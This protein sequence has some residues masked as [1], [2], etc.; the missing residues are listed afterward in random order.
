MT[1]ARVSRPPGFDMT[2]KPAGSVSF[3]PPLAESWLAFVYLAFSLLVLAVILYGYNAPSSS[4]VFAYIVE[5]DQHRILSSTVCGGILL[6]SALAA[7][8]RGQMRGVIIHPDG[9]EMRELLTFGIP[10]VRRYHWSQIDRVMV[11]AA[12][13]DAVPTKHTLVGI[14]LWDG[15]R[16]W[17][18]KVAKL[19]DLAVMIEK[20]ALAR[21]I[22]IDGGTGLIDDLGNPLD[23]DLEDAA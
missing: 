23:E 3:G 13:Q 8:I 15:S 10:K 7:V 14:D 6:A 18:P 2:Y 20:V 5:G 16:A 4:I 12:T 21:A 9:L 1:M 11:P 22:P 17:L 19:T